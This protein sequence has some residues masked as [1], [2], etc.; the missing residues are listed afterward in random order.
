MRHADHAFNDEFRSHLETALR[1]ALAI[2]TTFVLLLPS[3]RGFNET[4][5]W[6]PLWLLAMPAVALWALRGFPLPLRRTEES[7]PATHRRRAGWQARRR[8]RTVARRALA[9]AA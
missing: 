5:G 4:L 7:Q 1:Y 6:M 2:G 3:A 8:P 9:K